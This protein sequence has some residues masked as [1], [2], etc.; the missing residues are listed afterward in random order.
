MSMLIGKKKRQSI[1]HRPY[2]FECFEE[3]TLQAVVDK[4]GSKKKPVVVELNLEKA[5]N[6]IWVGLVNRSERISC[7]EYFKNLPLAKSLKQILLKDGD[8]SIY[9][10]V[11]NEGQDISVIG[12]A[13]IVGRE[14]GIDE[15]LLFEEDP[16]ILICALVHEIA[17]RGG[18]SEGK[19]ADNPMNLAA[20][21]ALPCCGCEKYYEEGK[22]G[23]I[24][25]QSTGKNS[26]R[27]V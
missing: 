27:F 26:S 8:F 20:E 4:V 13:C 21:K 11:P 22:L 6:K 25:M 23:M 10:L 5:I 2:H 19:A 14:I 7:N 12:Y 15:R 24:N 16:L 9:R 18:A 3:D 17:H 1:F